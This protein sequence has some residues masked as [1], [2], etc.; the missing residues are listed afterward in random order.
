MPPAGGV[1]PDIAVSM[2]AILVAARL[3]K[4]PEKE[5]GSV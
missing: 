2:A 1:N 4:V 3:R 5:P